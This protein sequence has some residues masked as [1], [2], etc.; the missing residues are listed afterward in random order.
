MRE[1]YSISF[2]ANL[3]EAFGPCFLNNSPTGLKNIMRDAGETDTLRLHWKGKG[4]RKGKGKGKRKG[5]EEEEQED[6][7]GKRKG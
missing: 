4:K 3:C 6:E 5:Q 7:E 2:Y 1:K